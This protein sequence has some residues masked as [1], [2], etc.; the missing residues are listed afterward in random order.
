MITPPIPGGAQISVADGNSTGTYS[1]T[2]NDDGATES[3]ETVDLQISN[4]STG[5][6]NITTASASGDITDNDQ[7]VAAPV[8]CSTTSICGSDPILAL[9]Q[10]PIIHSSIPGADFF[11]PG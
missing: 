7:F 10:S 11:G 5:L 6:V 1:V 2:V 8:V 9:Q 3:T 4:P